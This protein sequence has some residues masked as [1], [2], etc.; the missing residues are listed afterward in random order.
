MVAYYNDDDIRQPGNDVRDETGNGVA[1][2]L[3]LLWRY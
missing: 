3:V 2:L 1:V